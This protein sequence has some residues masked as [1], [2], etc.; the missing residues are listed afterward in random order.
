MHDLYCTYVQARRAK[1]GFFWPAYVTRV[2]HGQ[3]RYGDAARARR[4][5]SWRNQVRKRGASP[6][7]HSSSDG[8]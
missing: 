4:R 3:R 2:V 6:R 8:D 1:K 7:K 5:E